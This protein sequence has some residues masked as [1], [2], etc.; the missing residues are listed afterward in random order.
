MLRAVC[1][2]RA[3]AHLAPCHLPF[4]VTGSVDLPAVFCFL[5]AFG[6][7]YTFLRCGVLLYYYGAGTVA[8]APLR[9]ARYA[10]IHTFLTSARCCT[11]TTPAIPAR[12]P[13]TRCL[14][15]LPIAFLPTLRSYG[16][17]LTPITQTLTLRAAVPPL[18][19]CIWFV[20]PSP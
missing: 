1:T 2:R 5:L 11:L 3:F 10:R 6:F 16:I 12:H 15:T 17:T 7:I 13:S 4:T 9:D 14:V 19:M 20:T 18:F 8:D